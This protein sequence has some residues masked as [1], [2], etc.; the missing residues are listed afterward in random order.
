MEPMNAFLTQHRDSFKSFIDEVCHVPTHLTTATNL[1]S[2]AASSGNPIGIVGAETHLSYT[3]PMTIMQRLPPT[4]REGFPSL[5][6][7]IDQARAYAE[8]VQLWL[9]A[10]TAMSTATETIASSK[11]HA[12]LIAAIKASEGDLMAFHEICSTLHARTQECL[13][14]AERAERPNSALSFRWEELIDQLQTSNSN[15]AADDEPNQASSVDTLAER[16]ASDPLIIPTTAQPQ[17]AHPRQWNIGADGGYDDDLATKLYDTTPSQSGQHSFD[18]GAS[19]DRPGSSG[20]A[21]SLRDSLRRARVQSRQSN[22]PGTTSASLSNVSSRVS[23]DTEHTT[24]LPSYERE[25]RHRERREAAKQQIKQE[26][27]AARQREKEKEK[28]KR[29]VKTPI[30]S[31]L[32]K[33]KERESRSSSAAMS[34]S[35]GREGYT[36]HG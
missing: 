24:A 31:A 10:T 32:R 28:E 16:I 1:N 21:T 34:E 29:K 11:S 3:T 17:L 2:A 12:E 36:S 8:L 26:V 19:R 14:R 9:E 20:M 35:Y 6:Y 15:E 33:K 30:V 27:E 18:Y 25:T 13:N 4:S 5:P 22:S 23:S 7:L